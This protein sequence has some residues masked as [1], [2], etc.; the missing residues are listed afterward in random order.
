L[1][2]QRA[3]LIFSARESSYRPFLLLRDNSRLTVH[4]GI[5]VFSEISETPYLRPFN[6]SILYLFQINIHASALGLWVGDGLYGYPA[7]PLAVKPLG[8]G[9]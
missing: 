8:T 9:K 6:A 7:A 4:F 5:P 1:R 3:P 2:L